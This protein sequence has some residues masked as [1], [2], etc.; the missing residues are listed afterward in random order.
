MSLYLDQ[1]VRGK[2]ERRLKTSKLF[3]LNAN[4]IILFTKYE[5]IYFLQVY[6]VW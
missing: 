6:K 3:E 2:K 4:E 1:E 5:L